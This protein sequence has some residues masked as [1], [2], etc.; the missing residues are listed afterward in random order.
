MVLR[1][2][3]P[4]PDPLPPNP[5][6]GR[7]PSFQRSRKV[8][9]SEGCESA[10]P[11]AAGDAL[12][13]GLGPSG[14]ANEGAGTPQDP[15]PL[16]PKARGQRRPSSGCQSPWGCGLP[17]DRPGPEPGGRGRLFGRARRLRDA[18]SPPPRTSRASGRAGPGQGA[19]LPGSGALPDGSEER[20]PGA[21]PGVPR[22][23]APLPGSP[24]AA[25]QRS[26][27]RPPSGSPATLARG[28]RPHSPRPAA[29]LARDS[30][31]PLPPRIRTWV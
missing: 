24:G 19:S 15:S 30:P 8:V 3:P 2:G 25:P 16:R 11:G 23:P 4:G 7:V 17:R 6:K 1:V 5:P 29:P 27:P 9:K 12:S 22:P 28:D 13:R 18:P 31:I 10:T 26:P 14:P 20:P 21:G